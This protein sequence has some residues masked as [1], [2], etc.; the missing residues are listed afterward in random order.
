MVYQGSGN[1][2]TEGALKAQ[3]SRGALTHAQQ[4]A[5][6]LHSSGW[7]VGL[8]ANLLLCGEN[9]FKCNEVL[10]KKIFGYSSDYRNVELFINSETGIFS[11]Y[12]RTPVSV[13]SYI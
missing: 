11:I 3:C 10:W 6:K 5:G 12:I 8:I 13:S 2:Q 4:T 7:A 9:I 1:C